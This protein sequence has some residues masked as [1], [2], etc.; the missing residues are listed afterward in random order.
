MTMHWGVRKSGKEP[1]PAAPA[2]PPL[3][4]PDVDAE[5]VLSRIQEC[6]HYM[7]IRQWSHFRFLYGKLAEFQKLLS[8]QSQSVFVDDTNLAVALAELRLHAVDSILRNLEGSRNYDDFMDWMERLAEIIEDKRTFWNVLHT[9]VRPSL[10]VTLPQSDEISRH[11]FT[12][13]ERFEFSLSSF[14]S[15]SLCDLK[16]FVSIDDAIDVFYCLV[17][18][19]D[20]CHLGD[21]YIIN[22]PEYLDFLGQLLAASLQIKD[23]DARRFVWLLEAMKLHCSISPTS[24]R[25][26]C[27]NTVQLYADEK[28]NETPLSRLRSVSITSTSPSLQLIPGTKDAV[29]AI[30]TGMMQTQREFAH[31]YLFGSFASTSWTNDRRN[32]D[33][34]NAIGPGVIVWRLYLTNLVHRLEAMPE[35]PMTLVAAFLD[36]SLVFLQTYYGEIQASKR[37]SVKLRMELLEIVRVFTQYYP[38]Q[39]PAATKQKLWYLLLLVAISG[40]SPDDLERVA[41]TD[42]PE[43]NEVYLGLRHDDKD[44]E[45]YRTALCRLSKKFEAELELFPT[46]TQFVRAHYGQ[47]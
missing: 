35:V 16:A 21:G 5:N 24:F 11:F 2:G 28:T 4:S 37:Y 13:Q 47:E 19:I 46:M 44:F 41:K 26:I 30:F 9:E 20:S 1:A 3:P 14:L 6:H 34:P 18:F 39:V 42:C 32:E 29:M 23:Y 8:R 40:C 22:D 33:L 43:K 15:C 25:S 7:F 36:D 17:G 12:A 10:K 27:E 31:R 45:D 38:G